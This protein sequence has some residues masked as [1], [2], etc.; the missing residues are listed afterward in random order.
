M[1]RLMTGIV[2]LGGFMGSLAQDSSSSVGLLSRRYRDGERLSY[3]MKGHNNDR[4]HQVR[5]TAV[6]KRR[7]DGQFVEE[8]AW[9]D[10]VVDGVPE[11]LTPASREFRQ[12]VT[13]AGGSPFALPDLSRVQPGLIG[14]VTTC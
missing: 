12:A 5:L 10:L 4:T 6:V 13:L 2:V 3:L 1:I 14:P 8:Y 11:P 7:A 9:S